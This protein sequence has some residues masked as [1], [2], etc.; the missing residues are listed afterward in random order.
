MNTI[1]FTYILSI[2]VLILLWKSDFVSFKILVG[3]FILPSAL[4][5]G[6]SRYDNYQKGFFRLA[7]AKGRTGFKLTEYWAKIFYIST[8][9]AVLL[10]VISSLLYLTNLYQYIPV[11]YW[12]ILLGCT[13]LNFL[14]LALL[15]AAWVISHW[16]LASSR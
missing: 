11:Y 8:I 1:K 7:I 15:R 14:A 4:I 12:Q 13:F 10:T 6:K 9:I 2:V 5:I 3:Y 16:K